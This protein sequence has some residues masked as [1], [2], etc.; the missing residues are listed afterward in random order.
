MSNNE[1]KV[2]YKE[3]E[4]I[5][6]NFWKIVATRIISIEDEHGTQ[7][8]ASIQIP[9]FY[10]LADCGEKMART[11]ALKILASHLEP[12]TKILNTYIDII[13]E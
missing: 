3:D 1:A 10:I 7:W 5:D 4:P 2:E 6:N 9:T 13:L 11:K 12:D 8:K